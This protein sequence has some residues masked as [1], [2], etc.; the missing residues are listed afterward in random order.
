MDKQR[1]NSQLLVSLI[2]FGMICARDLQALVHHQPL[3]AITIGV[4]VVM[5][6]MVVV[7]LIM[8]V[9]R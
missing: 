6:L 2:L 9:R 3:S 8:R 4:T 1:A 7:S 5:G